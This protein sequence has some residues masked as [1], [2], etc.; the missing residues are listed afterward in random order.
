MPFDGLMI[1]GPPKEGVIE[2][3]RLDGNFDD[4]IL[5]D[6]QRTLL[7]GQIVATGIQQH[8]LRHQSYDFTTSDTHVKKLFKS[9]KGILK[10]FDLKLMYWDEDNAIF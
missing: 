1:N 9:E 4:F 7:L 2:F 8:F 10:R 6:A 5:A 3:H